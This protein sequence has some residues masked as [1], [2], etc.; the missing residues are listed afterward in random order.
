M[1]SIQTYIRRIGLSWFAAQNLFEIQ[2]K[3]SPGCSTAIFPSW[4]KKDFSFQRL[5][6]K[7]F[8]ITTAFFFSFHLYSLSE[9]N[10]CFRMESIVFVI[11][12]T[13]FIHFCPTWNAME[14]IG[15]LD[16]H[17]NSHTERILQ[18]K[19]WN[20]QKGKSVT[21]TQNAREPVVY[22][23]TFALQFSFEIFHHCPLHMD[24]E[25]KCYHYYL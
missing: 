25:A 20:S 16:T 24:H 11:K 2:W 15:K 5:L 6:C 8:F 7:S 3:C 14:Q 1:P 19:K 9:R 18:K 4:E 23:Y 17:K 22:F 12:E 13:S 10:I 21:Q